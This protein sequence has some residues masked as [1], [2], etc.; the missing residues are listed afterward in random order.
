[1][2]TILLMR[3]SKGGGEGPRIPAR[4]ESI[5]KTTIT[6]IAATLLTLW[7]CGTVQAAPPDISFYFPT[8][9]DAATVTEPSVQVHSVI[10]EPDLTEATFHWAGT[11]YTLYDSSLVLMF[12]FE[13]VAELGENYYDSPVR[14]MSLYGNDGT[15]GILTGGGIPTWN[16]S[17]GHGGGGFEFFG[18]ES[19]IVMHDPGGSL[20][21][22]A[23]DFAIALWVLTPS[24]SDADI[25]R[26]GSTDTGGGMWY[27][28]EHSAGGANKISLNFNTNGT[29]ATI[30]STDSYADS[31]WHFVVAQRKGNQAELWVDGVLN[32]T[33]TVSGE[34]Y[35][36]ANLTLG[37]KDTQDDDFFTGILDEV[38][39]Y[40]RSFS[41]DEVQ[42]LHNS[43]LS[44]YKSA[45]VPT[46]W[47]LD[48]TRDGLENGDYIYAV[49]ATNASGTTTNER[50]VTIALPAPPEVTLV[51]PADGSVLNNAIVTFTVDAVDP[52]GLAEAALYIGTP[53]QIATFSGPA[54]TD[55]AQLY[56]T[57]DSSTGEVEGPD[58]NAG[59]AVNINVDG[60]NPHA[61]A[62]IKFPNLIGSGAGQVPSNTIVV[63]ATL[64]VNCTNL[65]AMM[66]VYRLTSD[67][68]ESTVT[69]NSPWASPGGDYDGAVV[70]D[71]D[72]TATGLRTIDITEFVQAWSDGTANYGILLT[73]TGTDGIDFDSSEG[74]SPPVLTV[75]YAGDWQAVET[76]TLS[77]TSATV[78]FADVTLEDLTDYVWNCLVTNAAASPMSSWAV[79]NFNLSIDGQTPDEPL[80]VAPA[81]G[82]TGVAV[83]ATLEVIVS[84]PQA[85]VL[86]VTFYGRNKVSGPEEFTIVVL[87]DTQIYAQSHPDIFT[88]Q[89]QWIVDNKEALNIVF[90]THEGDIVQNWNSIT[91][92]ERANTSM[93]LLDGVVS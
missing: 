58:T 82:A 73:D 4:K 64:Q 59:G 8:P 9:D 91:E 62:V 18:A 69:W 89:T 33:A 39:I 36:E 88:S 83:P 2:L 42:L 43:N 47:T 68:S 48:V 54:E 80:L 70:V 46:E 11:D 22:G 72:C 56:E 13:N 15:L 21:P 31:Y 76:Q 16:E 84:D 93:S 50:T 25:M 32:G 63:S 5:M 74:A 45:T 40:M 52:A 79:E 34:I 26:K 24:N 17:L 44:K 14:D 30:Y 55:D 90:V 87:P 35:N 20:D 41:S 61:H 67:W 77:G 71:G 38:R 6:V 85:D 3:I 19:I 53:E 86:D 51:S 29:D 92:W 75:V 7:A 81:D 60:A 28:L 57:D 37:S 12:N 23:G 65:G 10:T 1:M 27:K 49:S 78:T 66:Q